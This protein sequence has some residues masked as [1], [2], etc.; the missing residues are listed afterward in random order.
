M[1]D[2][3]AA[4]FL[5]RKSIRVE[6]DLNY[7]NLSRRRDFI[8]MIPS[9]GGHPK[10]HPS[11]HPSDRDVFTDYMYHNCGKISTNKHTCRC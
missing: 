7:N 4:R 9:V 1:R 3:S 2:K 5:Y 11:M 6:P 10:R 8:K